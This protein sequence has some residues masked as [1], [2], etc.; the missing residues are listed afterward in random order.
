MGRVAFSAMSPVQEVI[1]AVGVAFFA[2]FICQGVYVMW[3]EGRRSGIWL[4]TFGT[5]GLIAM[6]VLPQWR[7]NAIFWLP[8]NVPRLRYFVPFALVGS[9]AIAILRRLAIDRSL[10]VTASRLAVELER[11]S[12]LARASLRKFATR[13]MKLPEVARF[14]TEYRAKFGDRIIQSMEPLV[15]LDHN[16]ADIRDTWLRMP[17][18]SGDVASIA[19][20]ASIFFAHYGKGE[21]VP[22][23][24]RQWF[25]RALIKSI[26]I[27]FIIAGVSW[28][29]VFVWTSKL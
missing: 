5:S 11:W 15:E 2:E 29:A 22:I 10:K 9:V 3:P 6:L 14:E 8:T 7:A 20:R 17:P 23:G 21:D 19:E 18:K 25:D 4:I 27:Y 16:Y 13:A 26:V 28:I 12:T 24:L 1:L